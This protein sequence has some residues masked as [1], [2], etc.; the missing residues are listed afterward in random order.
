MGHH[1][2]VHIQSLEFGI[3]FG[4]AQETK[5]EFAAL[6]GPTTLADGVA[7]VL[8]LC[9]AADA[10]V[11]AE[12]GDA[13]L[14]VEHGLEIFLG[15]GESLAADGSGRLCRVFEMDTKVGA[16]SLRRCVCVCECEKSAANA[17][18]DA[19]IPWQSCWRL[20]LCCSDPW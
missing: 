7:F 12:E 13:T 15:L 18:S 17:V 16:A 10:A 20:P 11:E 6:L 14:V 3:R 2:A 8:G 5:D 4:V 19:N 9:G 1:Q